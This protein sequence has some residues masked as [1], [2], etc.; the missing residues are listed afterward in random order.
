VEN[1]K[2][3]KKKNQQILDELLIL[4]LHLDFIVT[5]AL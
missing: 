1:K 2:Q 3:I 4:Y 5:S